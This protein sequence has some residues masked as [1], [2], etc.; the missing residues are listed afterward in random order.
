[1][2]VLEIPIN[3]CRSTEESRIRVEHRRPGVFVAMLAMILRKRL[4]R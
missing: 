2:W 1:M 3:Y 4:R